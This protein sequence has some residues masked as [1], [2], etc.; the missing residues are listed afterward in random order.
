MSSILAQVSPPNLPS[1]NVPVP[2]SSVPSAPELDLL[3]KQIDFLQEANQQLAK[4]F[5]SFVDTIKWTITI[6]GSL[7]GILVFSARS[8]YKNNLKEATDEITKNLKRRLEKIVDKEI[9]V[10]LADTVENRLDLV[11]R[12][13]NK[14][15]ILDQAKLVYL[16]PSNNSSSN[17]PDA[18]EIYKNLKFRISFETKIDSQNLSQSIVILDFT[19]LPNCSEDIVKLNLDK[20][21]QKLPTQSALVI[22][23]NKQ[24]S[25]IN[26]FRNQSNISYYA[27]ANTQVSLMG[28]VIDSA[29][30]LKALA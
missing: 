14:E 25:A 22:Y 16:L 21:V 23:C 27:I 11:E 2:N 28:Y 29:Y 15:A 8:I 10:R 19:N 12:V 1:P 5:Q 24:Y 7:L 6:V 30:I 26:E 20:I 18:Y 4:S 13:L 3:L 9:D 17:P